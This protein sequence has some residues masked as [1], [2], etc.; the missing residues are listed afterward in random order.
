MVSL[1]SSVHNVNTQVFNPSLPK[2]WSYGTTTV[3]LSCPV[4]KA[5]EAPETLFSNL[6][7]YLRLQRDGK[8]RDGVAC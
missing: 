3:R 6:V 4:R 2:R 7:R 5:H 1:Y 8:M